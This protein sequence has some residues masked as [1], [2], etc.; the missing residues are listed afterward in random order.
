V[1]QLPVV[2]L[3]LLQLLVVLLPLLLRN[4]KRLKKRKKN[5]T[6]IWDSDYSIKHMRCYY[7]VNKIFF[8][9]KHTNIRIS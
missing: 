6:Q 4:Q 9:K 8:L 7:K 2:L 5:P 3:K 1:L